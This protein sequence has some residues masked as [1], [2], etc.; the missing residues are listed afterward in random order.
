MPAQDSIPTKRYRWSS[1]RAKD[2]FSVENPATG[3]IITLVQ[4]GG[5]EQIDKAVKAAHHAFESDWRH[6]SPT[7]RGQLL[8]KAADLFEANADEIARIETLENGKPFSQARHFDVAALIML[9]RYFGSIVDKIP[10]DVIDHGNILTSVLLEPF[11]VVGAIIPFNWPPIHTAGKLA[12]ALAVGN[13]VV[14]KPG[15]QAPLTPSYIVEL[16]QTVLPPDVV[17]I[18]PGTG[19]I[20]GEALASHPLVRKLT[21][22]GSTKAGSA[23]IRSSADNITPTLLELGG[24]NAFLVFDDADLDR[25]VRNALEG[26]YFNQGEACTAA[27]RMIVQRG[28]YDA[29]VTR[30]AEGVRQLRVG[31]GMEPD[32][33]VGPLVSKAHQ[34]RVQSYVDHGIDSGLRV[35]AQA[36]LPS[37]PALAEG[38]YVRPTLFADVP[39]SHRLFEEEIFGPVSTVTVFD[40]EAEAVALCNQSEYGLVCGIHTQDMERGF[41]VAR[42]VDVGIVL[43]NTYNRGGVG[44]PFGGAKHTGFGR[45]H[46]LDTLKEFGRLKTVRHPSGLG[47]IPNWSAVDEIFGPAA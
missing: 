31:D 3:E 45:E 42:Q 28:I 22:T 24:K 25:V 40:T 16:L 41:R 43:F 23:V 7:E 38:F 17:Q 8:L 47:R 20:A 13:T 37:D 12:P 14:L 33:H 21:F 15:E 19:P 5:R 26:G 4:G 2:R 29:F 30:L 32:T 27:S 34:Q 9:F 46:C 39:A 6:R 10:G 1:N 11:G 18:V 35:A 36:E 44:M